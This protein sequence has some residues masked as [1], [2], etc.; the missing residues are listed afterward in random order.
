MNHSIFAVAKLVASV[1][2]PDGLPSL[3]RPPSFD[4]ARS[5]RMPGTKNMID[6][7]ARQLFYD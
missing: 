7:R 3:C 4:V 6:R 5:G 1:S 2:D